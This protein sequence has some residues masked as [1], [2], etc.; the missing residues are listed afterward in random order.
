MAVI[1]FLFNCYG[2]YAGKDFDEG[3]GGRYETEGRCGGG[4]NT[5]LFPFFYNF[6][7]LV[8]LVYSLFLG[9]SLN[10]GIYASITLRLLIS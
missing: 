3:P 1:F 5:A 10:P 4:S 9:G 2:T 6:I 7:H 8:I